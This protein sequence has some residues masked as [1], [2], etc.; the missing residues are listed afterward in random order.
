MHY[1][2]QGKI[3]FIVDEIDGCET[4]YS[5]GPELNFYYFGGTVFW[6]TS[7]GGTIF[8]MLPKL[9]PRPDQF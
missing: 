4:I 2:I 1:F 5:P 7:L 3:Y 6:S 9:V 8:N